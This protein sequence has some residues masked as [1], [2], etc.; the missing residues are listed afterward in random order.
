MGVFDEYNQSESIQEADS[1]ALAADWL[2]VG[3]ELSD[4]IERQEEELKV[5]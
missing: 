4:A 2:I 5:A 1:K 3:Q